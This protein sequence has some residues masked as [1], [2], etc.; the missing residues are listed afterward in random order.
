MLYAQ[1]NGIVLLIFPPN[2]SRRL[3][4]LGVAVFGLL[5]CRLAAHQ[6]DWFSHRGKTII[7]SHITGITD[8]A[9]NLSFIEIIL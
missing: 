2:F 6:N 5:K 1:E 9:F 3:Q 7:V 8:K 4:P